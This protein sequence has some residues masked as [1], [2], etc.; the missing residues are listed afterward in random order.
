M[1][2][3]LFE[4]DIP[5]NLGAI[6][7]I[8]ACF[9]MPLDIIEPCGFLLTDKRLKRAAMDYRH[10]L[11]L[12][13]HDSFE[14]FLRACEETQRL[15]LFTTRASQPI[16]GFDFKADDILLFGRESEGAPDYVHEAA[17]E[18]LRISI[19]PETRS[20]NLAVSVGIAAYAATNQS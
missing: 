12:Q 16:E 10:H 4:P 13:R 19:A 17:N 5:Q 20:L 2:I 11:K 3:A 9:D 6:M 18:R 1:R 7:R 8:A 15:L 14:H